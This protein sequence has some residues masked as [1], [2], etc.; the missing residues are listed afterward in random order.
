MILAVLI[1]FLG[2]FIFLSVILAT[3]NP[4]YIGASLALLIYFG[5]EVSGAHFNPAITCVSLY[6]KGI[7]IYTAIAYILAQVSGGLLA[8]F[9]YS[10]SR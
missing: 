8:A 4:W 9:A 3:G 6:N 7:N 10:Y 1:E 2:T 5:L